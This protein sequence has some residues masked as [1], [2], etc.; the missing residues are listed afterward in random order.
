MFTLSL[1]CLQIIFVLNN[2]AFPSKSHECA[3][4]LTDLWNT[5]ASSLFDL[6]YNFELIGASLLALATSIY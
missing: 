6:N 5:I 1:D 3:L 4:K 2:L